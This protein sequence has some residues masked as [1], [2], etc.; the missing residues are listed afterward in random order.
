MGE[1]RAEGSQAGWLHLQRQHTVDQLLISLR[2]DFIED[3]RTLKLVVR[4][5]K[6][7][8]CD[9]MKSME[10]FRCYKNAPSLAAR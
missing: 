5:L 6:S 2:L 1:L 7:S 9:A 3:I 4:L 8:H 10:A